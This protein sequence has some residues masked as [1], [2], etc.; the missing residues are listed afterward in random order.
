M[1]LEDIRP[2]ARFVRHITINENSIFP[3]VLPV[4]ARLFYVLSGQGRIMVDG[5]IFTLNT[6]S[7]LYINAKY[8]YHILPSNVVY[9]VVNFDFT[10]DRAML[11]VP[12]PPLSADN[13]THTTLPERI[14]F[15]NAPCFHGYCFFPHAYA[16]QQSFLQLEQ[17][18]ARK[19]AFHKQACSHL[20]ASILTQLARSAEQ[21]QSK[22]AY[23]DITQIITYIQE[24]YAEPLDNQIIAQH[25]HFHPNYISN[26]FKR[27]V[28]K[29]LHQYVLETRMLNA[30][31][32]I[33]GG[34]TD[35]S[36]IAGRTGFPDP[37]YFTRYFKKF[38]GITPTQYIRNY[39]Q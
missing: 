31:M 11:D 17:E 35:I 12:I 21:R 19:M 4:D 2:F 1:H 6:G 8:P 30:A 18:Y 27:T 28:G 16:L 32:L 14:V 23:F 37:N 3:A 15:Q 24:H 33:E 26:E 39:K 13:A 38:F 22:E 25:F 34:L 9:L 7:T 5:Q 20:L 36:T 10:F 29:S